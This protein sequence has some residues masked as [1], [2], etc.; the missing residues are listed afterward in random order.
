[1]IPRRCTRPWP[2]RWSTA[3]SRFAPSRPQAR[4][5]G[6][7]ERPAWPMIVLRSPKGWTGPK[8]V[9]GHKV[10]DF[11]RAHQVPILDPATN[12]K[13]LQ[14]LDDW[15]R[16]YRPE[17][18][19]DESGT[20]DSPSCGRSAPQGARRISANP[21]ANGGRL[22]KP[23]EPA[24]F[25][26]LRRAGHRAGARAMFRRPPPSHVSLAEV[27]RRNMTEFPRLRSG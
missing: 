9:N 21:H 12:P 17:E 3:S 20:A 22:R 11:W 25:S 24:A 6:R 7:V 27:M 8:T 1:M 26:R 5:T 2:R 15:M 13:S 4:S 14:I 18:L 10:E 19:F 23:L 16:S